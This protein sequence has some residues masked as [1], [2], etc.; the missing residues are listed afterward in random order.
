MTIAKTPYDY[1]IASRET[2]SS[3][4]V[5]HLAA[6]YRMKREGYLRAVADYADLLAA[7]DIAET[8]LTLSN[9]TCFD[10]GPAGARC[11][12]CLGCA[13]AGTLAMLRKALAKAKGQQL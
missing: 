13:V 12:S 11:D 10:R 4:A 8:T 1:D 3:S 9:D 5:Q 2:S 6:H 7:A